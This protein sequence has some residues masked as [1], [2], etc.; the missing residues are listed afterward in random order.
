LPLT[1]SLSDA[2]ILIT[3]DDGIGAPGL[4]ILEH[5]ARQHCDDVWVVAPAQNQSSRSRAMTQATPVAVRQLDDTRFAVEGTPADCAIIGLNGLLPGRTPDLVLSGINAGSNLGEEI[6]HSGTVGA[7]LQAREQHIPGLAFSQVGLGA[8]QSPIDWSCARH[9]AQRLLPSL[10]ALLEKPHDT[11][12]V[13]FPPL[14]D[15][16]SLNGTVV[17]PAG[18]RLGAP[19]VL[20]VSRRGDASVFSYP[21][22]RPGQRGP[23][24][25][26]WH[27]I[28]EGNISIT[29]IALDATHHA[30][31]DTVAERLAAR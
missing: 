18:L 26:D 15:P 5:A 22:L 13:N 25:S 14:R 8:S 16:A 12:N 10:V 19:T 11:M 23:D 2:R 20:P 17:V 30:V 27:A 4:E 6:A 28:Y 1:P 7:C 21:E 31:I 9:H 29:P 24:G 3:N